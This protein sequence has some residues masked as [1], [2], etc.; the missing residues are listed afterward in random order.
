MDLFIL[1][2]DNSKDL[3][4]ISLELSKNK[5][6]VIQEEEHFKLMKKKRY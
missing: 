4:N 3:E 5:F 6:N 2:A 1:K